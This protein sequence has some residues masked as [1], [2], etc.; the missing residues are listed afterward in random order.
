MYFSRITFNSH[1]D[2]DQLAKTFCS[3][4]YR[5]HQA[6]WQLFDNDPEAKRDFLYRQVNE[7]GLIKYYLLSQR[8]PVDKNGIWCVSEPKVFSPQ[9]SEGQKLYFMLRVNPVV[10][11]RTPDGRQYRHDVI[12]HEKQRVSYKNMPLIQRPPMQQLIQQSGIKWL[13][14]RKQSNGFFFEP[15]QV[16]VDSYQQHRVG[17]MKH[18]IQYST[19]DFQGTLTVINVDLFRKAL[20]AGIGKCKAFGCGLLLIK[21]FK[22]DS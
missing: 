20:F 15:E 8:A 1:A 14:A 19:L 16:M 18:F 17:K 4:S 5:E 22:S 7:Y 13:S 12:M 6:L 2:Q 9:L 10:T 3:N 21:P 11:T